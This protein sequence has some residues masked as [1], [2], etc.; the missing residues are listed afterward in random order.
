M[1]ALA[2]A[3][4]CALS[5][6][7]RIPALLLIPIAVLTQALYPFQYRHLIVA[8]GLGLLLLGLRNGLVLVVALSAFLLVW[9]RTKDSGARQSIPDLQGETQ[10]IR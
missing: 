1:L 9:K 6:P 10:G 2:A 5:S 3:A 7:V 8:D 4:S